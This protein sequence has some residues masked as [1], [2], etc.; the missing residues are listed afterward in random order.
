MKHRQETVVLRRVRAPANFIG[1]SRQNAAQ[2]AVLPE[3]RA[4]MR[5]QAPLDTSARGGPSIIA[6]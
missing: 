2:L 1:K 3:T 5:K 6:R 4:S